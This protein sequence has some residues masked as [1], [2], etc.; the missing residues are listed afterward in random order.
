MLSCFSTLSAPSLGEMEQT[1]NL[2]ERGTIITKLYPKHRPEQ[3]KLILVRET[4]QLLWSSASAN[5]RTDFEGALELR[6]VKEVRVGK[7]SKEFRCFVDDTKKFDVGKCFVVL[8]GQS[9]KLKTFSVVAFSEQECE[10]WVKGIKY[11]VSDTI[12]APYSLQLERWLRK[13][14]YSIENANLHSNSKEGGTVTVKDFK[15]FLAGVSCKIPTSKLM[16]YFPE[17]DI[18]KKSD[19][20]FDD[21]SRLY[22]NL[23]MPYN[24][25]K[26]CF[27]AGFIYSKDGE[28]VTLKEFQSFLLNEQNDLLGKD[29]NAISNYICNF[30]QDIERETHEPYLTIAEFVDYL[31]SK[32][33]EIWDS[34]CDKVYMDMKQPMSHY[35]IASSHNTYLTGDQF[36]SESSIEAYARAL[37]MGCRCIELDCWNGPDNLPHIFH[38]HTMTSKIKFIDVIKTIKEHAFV[39]SDFPVILSIEQN[40]SLEQQ[41]NMAQALIDV[42]GDMLLVQRV[43]RN[44]TYLPSPYQLRKKIILKHKKLPEFEEGAQARS[45]D[46]N[47]NVRNVLKEGKLFFK[48][49]CDKTWNPYKFVLT[50]QE[51]I[52]SSEI[53]ENRDDD[54][55]QSF[56]RTKE[57]LINDELHFGENWFHGR[58]EGGRKEADDL[59]E[60]YKHLGDGT[61]LVR[62]SATFVGDY[63]LSF[64]RRGRANHCRIKLK[65]EN[66]TTK[67]YLLDNFMFDS[68]Y[69][70]IM[71]YRQNVLRSS[72]FS[73][74]L[75]EP[76]PQP[77]KHESQEWFHSN[78]TKEQAEAVLIRLEIGSFLV[79]P[80]EQNANA[81]VISFTVNCKIKHCRIKVDGRLYV[82]GQ[83][84]FESLVSLVNYYMRN[85]LYRNVKLTHPVSKDALR[86]KLA[87]N[88]VV[89][90]ENGNNGCSSYMDPSCTE[91]RVTCKALYS[92][93]ANK[94]DELS[95]AKHAII[96]NVLRDN[97]MWWMGDYGGMIQRFFP[98]NYVKVIESVSDDASSNIS[99]DASEFCT[100]T[101]SIEIHGAVASLYDSHDAGI[102]LKMLIQTPM[103]QNIFEI[104]FDNRDLAFE[105]VQAIQAAAQI[106]SQL[107]NERRKKERN[108]RVAKE[109]SDLIIYF[110]SVPFR[111]TNWVFYEMSSFPETKAEKQFLQQNTLLFLSYHR[112]Q[113]SRVYPKGQRLDSSNFNP[114]NF[115]NVGS[116]MIALNYQTADK[117][118][119]LNQAKFR[120]NGSCGYILKPN[121]MFNSIFD[122]NDP[123]TLIGVP[124]KII[125][126]RIIAARHLCR[127]GKNIPNNPLVAIEVLGASFDTGIKHKTRVLDNG[128]NPFWNE[129]CEFT[130]RNPYFALLRFEVQDED[131]FA[132]RHFVAQG[133]FPVQCLLTGYRSIPL[134]NK[135]NEELELSSLLVHISIK[136]NG[137][138][139]NCTAISQNAERMLTDLRIT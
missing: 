65:H 102:L 54:F 40:C 57:N 19:L 133:T 116:Q 127:S 10:N 122:P 128:F 32:Q 34:R 129:T 9:F 51:L 61:F 72:E 21:F 106:A 13:E 45:S 101:D 95:F 70:L 99:D 23:L 85:P 73:I 100:K 120:D 130:V 39:T 20:R 96:T 82:V 134:R 38:G 105:W 75:R 26:D 6:D 8:Y 68:L 59:L 93:K 136:T 123:S 37:R 43:D 36:S 66:G 108:A 52:Y 126:I 124:E 87:I 53:E 97:S 11:M 109:M 63:S 98:A 49:P 28:N 27:G 92:Y 71:Y 67:Y 131:M 118:M 83:T 138:D 90:E 48:D 42:F 77:K 17:D 111:E 69:S 29:E 88:N 16:E 80:S 112:Q 25:I 44:E 56:P 117:P 74:M 119:Q 139:E 14:Y 110:R 60:S 89:N 132:E 137:V 91:E 41:R 3:K 1:I 47:E 58:L 76:V 55:D 30:I 103:M 35:W 94:P 33:N 22:R 50:Q 31:F 4:R 18:R 115:W 64:W 15:S 24:F 107:E 5:T 7:N 104:G 2:L 62:E 135:F 12:K 81:F 114:I 46:E 121:F 125:T 78:T 84:P 113:I 86:N 79:R